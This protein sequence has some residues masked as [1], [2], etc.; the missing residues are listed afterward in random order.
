ME[1]PT[2]KKRSRTSDGGATNGGKT[3]TTPEPLQPAKKRN[4]SNTPTVTSKEASDESAMGTNPLAT[5]HTS[6]PAGSDKKGNAG[7]A[8]IAGAKGKNI[9]HQASK[10]GKQF[11]EDFT[12]QFGKPVELKYLWITGVIRAVCYSEQQKLDLLAAHNIGALQ[13]TVSR[14][15]REANNTKTYLNKA[16]IHNVHEEYTEEYIIQQT[17]AA[18][19]KRINRFQNGQLAPTPVVVLEFEGIPPN[20]VYIEH[21]S[22]RTETFV[23]KPM[24]CTHCQQYRH[25]ARQCGGEKRCSYCGGKHGVDQCKERESGHRPTCR[26]CQGGHEAGDRIC[27]KFQAIKEILTIRAK[28]HVT[29][30]EALIIAQANKKQNQTNDPQSSHNRGP[31]PQRREAAKSETTK[32]QTGTN[33][34][35]LEYEELYPSLPSSS[36]TGETLV[37]TN[38]AQKGTDQGKSVWGMTQRGG[39]QGEEH[40]QTR[41]QLQQQAKEIVALQKEAENQ[42]NTITQQEKQLK[43]TCKVLVTSISAIFNIYQHSE[44]KSAKT[45]DRMNDLKDCIKLCG[46]PT[47][48]YVVMIEYLKTQITEKQVT[49]AQTPK[50][51][52]EG[53]NSNGTQRQQLD[54]IDNIQTHP[55]LIAEQQ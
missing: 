10:T 20:K 14:P 49:A 54:S 5:T 40:Q 38:T 29:Y 46:I 11:E 48:E 1:K 6:R 34:D 28:Q 21:S 39:A 53:A 16:V 8:Y 30:S 33:A 24:R 9:V 12:A 26:N 32:Q 2:S 17:G 52:T 41:E 3:P 47:D 44:N 31:P 23:P 45:I 19:A 15:Y 18:A 27:P 7:I 36:Y 25:T 43:T 22:Y 13:V 51:G 35:T 55:K 42:R 4:Q 37:I 50:T